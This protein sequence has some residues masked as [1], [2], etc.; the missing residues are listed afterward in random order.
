MFVSIIYTFLKNY[1]FLQNNNKFWRYKQNLWVW[2]L[3]EPKK[4]AIAIKEV[5]A[6]ASQMAAY[7]S[8]SGI[9]CKSMVDE[10]KF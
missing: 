6:A 1:L 4:V 3:T 7:K 9:K 5:T 8:I 10:M 2:F